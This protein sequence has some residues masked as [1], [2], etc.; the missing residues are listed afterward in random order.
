M[1]LQKSK[2]KKEKKEKI[3][4]EVWK[5]LEVCRLAAL[6]YVVFVFYK[7]NLHFKNKLIK[8]YLEIFTLTFLRLHK[9][10]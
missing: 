4:R 10:K 6:K 9:C 3:A 8:S 5:Y 2:P 7:F 1:L